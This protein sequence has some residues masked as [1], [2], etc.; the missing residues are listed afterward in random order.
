[1]CNARGAANSLTNKTTI[2][3]FIENGA[4]IGVQKRTSSLLN[5]D[6]ENAACI[7]LHKAGPDGH[8]LKSHE[9]KFYSRQY[10][11]LELKIVV[12]HAYL[13]RS[14]REQPL[15]GSVGHLNGPDTTP[16]SMLKIGQCYDLYHLVPFK[17]GTITLDISLRSN[18]TSLDDL[19]SSGA[20]GDQPYLC[21]IAS[22]LH[23]CMKLPK[24]LEID[25][26]LYFDPGQNCIHVDLE[27]MHEG[28]WEQQQQRR[29]TISP[30][31]GTLAAVGNK[32]PSRALPMPRG[33]SGAKN[34][35]DDEMGGMSERSDVENEDFDPDY[36]PKNNLN[37]DDR[38][39][40]RVRWGRT[41]RKPRPRRRRFNHEE[42][43][44]PSSKRQ[45]G[46]ANGSGGHI[47][48]G[49]GRMAE[50]WEFAPWGV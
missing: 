14:Q 5:A 43:Q 4:A 47:D 11:D 6:W 25:L 36:R 26:P 20:E 45:A 44:P 1:M 7:A 30:P 40:Y 49:G 16:R 22:Q 19:A 48:H 42:G 46:D 41:W 38:V 39:R 33:S 27:A 29:V 50:R 21:V 15:T 17:A 18:Y 13:R 28:A 23:G 24:V 8:E 35:G 9:L 12:D 3:E 37:S 34:V 32:E 2:L 10:G 31:S